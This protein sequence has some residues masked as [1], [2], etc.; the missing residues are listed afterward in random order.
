MRTVLGKLGVLV[1]EGGEESKI[2]ILEETIIE[3]IADAIE[4]ESF[5]SLPIEEIIKI[6]K[7]SESSEVLL[8][9]KLVSNM[10]E[11]KEEASPLI[12]KVIDSNKMS[13]DECIDI[14]SCLKSCTICTRIG[15]LYQ[16]SGS[17][18]VVDFRQENENLKKRNK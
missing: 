18:P 7:K 3:D 17:L 12:L 10:S 9:K 13:I 2:D 8:L 11:Y 16:A 5:Y 6:I 4:E 15:Q 1:S 14:I